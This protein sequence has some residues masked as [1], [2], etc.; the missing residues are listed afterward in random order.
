MSPAF[1]LIF[2]HSPKVVRT[3]HELSDKH[4]NDG[5][6]PASRHAEVLRIVETVVDRVR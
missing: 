3:A 4:F 5:P 2:H 6:W 1:D